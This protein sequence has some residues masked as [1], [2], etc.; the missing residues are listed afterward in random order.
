M[1]S[2]SRGMSGFIDVPC[3]L[4]KATREKNMINLPLQT[5][6]FSNRIT[7]HYT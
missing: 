2:L 1:T 6:E 4:I 5:A 7:I 3:V